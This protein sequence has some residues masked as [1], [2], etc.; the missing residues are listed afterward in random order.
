[1]GRRQAR[2]GS[3]PPNVRWLGPVSDE[4][5]PALYRNARALIFPGEEDFGLT[6]LE[7]QA[8][9]RPVIAL[10]RGGALETVT[11]QT[12]ILF[13]EQTAEALANAVRSFDRFER[14][15]DPAAARRNALQ[16][17]R[18]SFQA[19]YEAQVKALLEEARTSAP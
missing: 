19:R 5:I 10:A 9:G 15:F 12:G 7:A 11:P 6:P 4:E 18:A 3:L 14:R 16:F 2:S 13:E 17:D 8:A 1:M